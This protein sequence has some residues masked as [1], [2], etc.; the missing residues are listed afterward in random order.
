[1]SKEEQTEPV[2]KAGDKV[3]VHYT[4]RLEDG[5][6]FA[7]T[8][9]KKAKEFLVGGAT[10]IP[11]LQEAVVGMRPGERKTVSIP[12]EKAYG[13][14]HKEM[15]AVLSRDLA[16]D[17]IELEI[18]RVIRVKHADGHESDVFITAITGESIS[19]DGNHPLA[20]KRL[21]MEIEVIE[22]S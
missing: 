1:M 5:T 13:P 15:T 14:Y 19:V 10:F 3:R 20:G 8:R 7:T 18:G 12:P 16:P 22:C 11:G 9:G 17:D 4:C 2:V 6:V 21:E